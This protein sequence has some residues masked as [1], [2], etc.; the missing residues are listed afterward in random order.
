MPTKPESIRPL[1]GDIQIHDYSESIGNV[2]E[3]ILLSL[4][5]GQAIKPHYLMRK[6]IVDSPAKLTLPSELDIVYFSEMVSEGVVRRESSSSR[7]SNT[8]HLDP[9]LLQSIAQ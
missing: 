1:R 4:R 7:K 3:I 2:R 5:P 8:T 9:E 6:F